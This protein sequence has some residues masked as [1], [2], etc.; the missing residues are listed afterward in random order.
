MHDETSDRDGVEID[1]EGY[2]ADLHILVDVRPRE[3]QRQ[4]R[5]GLGLSAGHKDGVVPLG[6]IQFYAIDMSDQ[7][8]VLM[9]MERMIRKCAI[10]HRPFL[11]VAGDHVVE[12]WLVR[13]EQSTLLEIDQR[14]VPVVV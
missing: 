10:E 8:R 12:Q 11:V 13:V 14:H 3:W 5:E 7:K 4:R 6:Y 9:D 1:P 2:R